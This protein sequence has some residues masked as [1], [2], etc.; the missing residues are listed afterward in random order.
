[1]FRAFGV[2]PYGKLDAVVPPRRDRPLDLTALWLDLPAWL[3]AALKGA[4]ALSFV[5]WGGPVGVGKTSCLPVRG[6]KRRS[7]PHVY[8]SAPWR[9]NSVQANISGRTSETSMTTSAGR[10]ALRAAMRM[11]SALGAS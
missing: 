2:F 8:V 4:I 7:K 10:L 9:H 11:A 1:M 6:R 5:F 3:Q